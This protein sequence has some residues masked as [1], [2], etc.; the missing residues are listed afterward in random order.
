MTRADL[1]EAMAIAAWNATDGAQ[2]W[3]ATDPIVRKVFRSYMEPALD[4]IAAAGIARPAAKA[5]A[6]VAIRALLSLDI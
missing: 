3:E 5:M 6:V 2:P 4:A 1:I